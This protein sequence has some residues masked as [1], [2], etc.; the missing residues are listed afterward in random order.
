MRSQKIH[1]ILRSHQTESFLRNKN[2]KLFFR[3][4]LR[5]Q[6]GGVEEAPSKR[7][8]IFRIIFLFLG[9]QKGKFARKSPTKQLLHCQN[10]CLK[11]SEFFKMLLRSAYLCKTMFSDKLRLQL[12]IGGAFTF[13]EKLFSFCKQLQTLRLKKVQENHSSDFRENPFSDFRENPSSGNST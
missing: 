12:K 2:N 1:L 13:S 4:Y 11:K 5:F 3:K 6:K 9:L 7:R 10:F 8:D